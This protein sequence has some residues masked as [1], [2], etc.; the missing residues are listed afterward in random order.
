M[1]IYELSQSKS[2]G[3]D[4]Y[5]SCVV[6]AKSPKDARTIHPSRDLQDQPWTGEGTGIMTWAKP[7]DVTVVHIGK[8]SR[9]MKRG[10]VVSSFNAG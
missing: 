7:E 9:G 5:D 6:I 10:L 8:A 2:K 3:L 4:T 1:N